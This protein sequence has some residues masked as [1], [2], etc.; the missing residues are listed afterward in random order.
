MVPNAVITFVS[1]LYPGSI[2]DKETVKQSKQLEHMRAGDLIL[3]DKGFFIQDLVPNGV[4]I[5]IP[6]FL[7]NGKFT[8]SE[9]IAAKSIAK[10]GIHVER[11]NARL[12]DFKIL[13]FIP[14]YLRSHVYL[15]IQLCAALVNLQSPQIKEGCKDIKFE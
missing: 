5:N 6:P 2:S 9:V 10:C 1:N 15:V 12:K 14:P 8:E 11:A 3:A 13:N 4:H 7:Q